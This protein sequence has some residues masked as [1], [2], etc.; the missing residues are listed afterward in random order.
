MRTSVYMC[1]TLPV[2]EMKRLKDSVKMVLGTVNIVF[3]VH[4]RATRNHLSL[5][6]FLDG[7][8][9]EP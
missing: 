3:C 1:I 7:K 2:I 6:I 5:Y 9:H 8:F 4:I